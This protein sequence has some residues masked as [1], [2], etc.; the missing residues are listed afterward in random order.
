MK[1]IGTVLRMVRTG[2]NRTQDSVGE[3]VGVTG[4]Y[5]SA[6]ELGKRDPSWSLVQSICSDLQVNVALVVLLTQD[7]DDDII[8]F[9]HAAYATLWKQIKDAH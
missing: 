4:S 1:K 7:E 5:I 2:Q 6:L 8:P 3:S 9:L